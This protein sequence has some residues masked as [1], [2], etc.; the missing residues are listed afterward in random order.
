[1][2]LAGLSTTALHSILGLV[3]PDE[4]QQFAVTTKNS[5]KKLVQADLVVDSVE[6]LS[7]QIVK[8]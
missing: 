2:G 3:D 6:E 1:M 4:F 5:C 8:I 7:V